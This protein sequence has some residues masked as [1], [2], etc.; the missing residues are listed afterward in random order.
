MRVNSEGWFPCPDD[1]HRAVRNCVPIH[2][3]AAVALLAL[4][5]AGGCEQKDKVMSDSKMDFGGDAAES[6]TIDPAVTP[7][8]FLKW[9]T[10]RLGTSN[11][12]RMNNPVWEWLVKSRANAFVVNDRLKGPSPFEA[13]PGWCFDRFGQ[14]SNQ[15]PD[16]RVVFIAGEH[17]DSYDPDFYIYNDVVVQHP[18]GRIEIFGYPR[19][20]FPPTDFHSAT[21]VSNRIVL[22]GNL[23]YP[24]QRAPGRTQVMSLDL[25]TLAISAV[26]TFGT[27]PRWIHDHQA[28]LSE[29]GR[30]ILIQRGKLDRGGEGKSL[31]ENI[32]DWKLHLSDWRWERLTERRWPR[33]E[34]RRKDGELNHLF[35]YQQAVW[36]KKMPELGKAG[37]E[38]NKN[39]NIPT[40]EEELGKPL[41]LEL[42][43]HLYKPAVAHEP[44]AKPDDE[45]NVY[46]IKVEGVVVRYVEEMDAIQVTVEGDLPQKTLDALTHDLIDK[47]SALENTPC[48]LAR[49]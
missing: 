31:V 21:L 5:L 45:H 16:G 23:G 6:L 11:P 9:R 28:T 36:A 7:E 44:V 10:P 49:L 29:D 20:V 25:D 17:E 39:L 46:R 19:E 1:Y 14:S 34:V 27:S 41:D 32:D 47:L 3:V 15:L 12:E 35:D 37:R 26:Q 4:L 2:Q 13:G 42:F 8:L 43:S 33:W 18:D 40:A 38:L 22:I 30:S 24:D 48:E